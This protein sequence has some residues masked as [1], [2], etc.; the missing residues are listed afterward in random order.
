MRKTKSK[1][2]NGNDNPHWIYED[3][4]KPKGYW[5]CKFSEHTKRRIRRLHGRD[6]AQKRLILQ[7]CGSSMLDIKVM[8]DYI[9][10]QHSYNEPRE[11]LGDILWGALASR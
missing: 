8:S 6:K 5:I 2:F 9:E 7:Q 10:R 3:L 4:E 11:G 1:Y